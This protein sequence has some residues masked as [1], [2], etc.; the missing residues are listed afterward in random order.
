VTDLTDDER[1]LILAALF[2]LWI[3]RAED[4]GKRAEIDALVVK[5]G[6][7]PDTAM[8]GAYQ[9]DRADDEVPLV[10]YPADETDEG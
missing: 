5:L 1:D 3:A 8:F 4:A 7:D 10:E 2:D 9:D 6:G